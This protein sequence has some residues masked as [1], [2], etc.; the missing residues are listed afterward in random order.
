M[1]ANRST[2]PEWRGLKVLLDA[3]RIIAASSAEIGSGRASTAR[4]HRET[5]RHPKGNAIAM[6][7]TWSVIRC[8]M[9]ALGI[10]ASAHAGLLLSFDAAVPGTIADSTGA[11][12][13]FTNR[14]PGTGG[15]LPSN[16][17]HLT[18]QTG[19]SQLLLQSTS[20]NISSGGINIGNFEAVGFYLQGIRG[21]DFQIS[22]VVLDVNL[23]NLSDQLMLYA[24]TSSTS[25][26]RGGVHE[27]NQY[28]LAENT[29]GY[30]FSSWAGSGLSAFSSGDSLRITLGRTN[31]LWQLSWD[32][33]TTSVSGASTPYSVGWLNSADDLYVGISAANA[34]SNVPFVGKIASFS[35]TAVPEIDPAGFGSVLALASGVLGMLE[36]RRPKAS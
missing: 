1:L 30:D 13:G 34:R 33:L 17:P 25:V 32:N 27:G 22:A 12:T 26:V 2:R 31:G 21:G 3:D 20:A 16:D 7:T 36:R 11:G 14:L 24:G 6:E 4:R 8:M 10:S 23:P 19:Q 18:L 15:A 9:L 29:G 35:V 5:H 28:F